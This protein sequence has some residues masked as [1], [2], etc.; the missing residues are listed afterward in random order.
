M[1]ETVTSHS[2][3]SKS[4]SLVIRNLEPYNLGTMQYIVSYSTYQTAGLSKAIQ[5]VH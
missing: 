3:I 4:L 2:L 5:N 1:R